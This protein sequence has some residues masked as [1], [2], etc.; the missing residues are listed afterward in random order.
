MA[1]IRMN[2]FINNFE[3]SLFSVSSVCSVAKKI[4]FSLFSV[5]SVCSV[6]KKIDFSVASV[7][8]VAIINETPV[9]KNLIGEE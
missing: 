2:Q 5:S 3:F 6:A 8:S 4:E 7:P 1:L 9:A